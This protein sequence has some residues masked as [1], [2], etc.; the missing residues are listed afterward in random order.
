MPRGMRH[1]QLTRPRCHPVRQA[2]VVFLRRFN[3]PA[4][5]QKHDVH[6]GHLL[7]QAADIRKGPQDVCEQLRQWM[8]DDV[9]LGVLD[10]REVWVQRSDERLDGV[11]C[12]GALL[13]VSEEVEQD[14]VEGAGAGDVAGQREVWDEERGVLAQ[15]AG[16]DR[17]GGLRR[18]RGRGEIGVQR[19]T[20]G[21]VLEEEVYA[22]ALVAGQA[23]RYVAVVGRHA[24]GMA[25][26]GVGPRAGGLDGG[27]RGRRQAVQLGRGGDLAEG[28]VEGSRV[29]DV[30]IVQRGRVQRQ[31]F[32]G[33]GELWGGTMSAQ[34]SVRRGE[35]LPPLRPVGWG[36]STGVRMATALSRRLRTSWSSAWTASLLRM[37]CCRSW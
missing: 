25:G 14:S 24:A 30:G 36:R 33:S 6:N 11:P 29:V 34:S 32:G 28:R 37:T 15:A 5:D 17:G 22:Q 20:L 4:H 35:K 23:G 8:R 13:A 7:R 9:A 26:G 2:I 31:A 19:W 27:G 18:R 12:G 21:V 1:K 16:A 10:G 3:L